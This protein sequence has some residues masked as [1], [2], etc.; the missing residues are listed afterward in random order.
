MRGCLVIAEEAPKE[1][2]PS[3]TTHIVFDTTQ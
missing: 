3:K 2:L 1:N